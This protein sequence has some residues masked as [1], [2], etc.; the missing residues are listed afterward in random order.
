[1]DHAPDLGVLGLAD[2][3]VTNV[4]PAVGPGDAELGP[5]HLEQLSVI[6]GVTEERPQAHPPPA[7]GP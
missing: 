5:D 6:A 1:M 3:Q 7:E 4:L 2:Q